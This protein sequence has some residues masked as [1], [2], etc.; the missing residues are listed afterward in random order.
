MVKRKG[1][2]YVA[3]VWGRSIFRGNKQGSDRV[4]NRRLQ[5]AIVNAETKKAGSK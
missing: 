2:I 4:Q 3:M 5:R 1:G